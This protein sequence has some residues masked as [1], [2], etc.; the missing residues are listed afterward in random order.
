M[1]LS[2]VVVVLP[3]HLDGLDDVV[4]SI[5]VVGFD[6]KLLNPHQPTFC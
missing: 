4:E 1:Y 6:V 2:K 5:V 3:V